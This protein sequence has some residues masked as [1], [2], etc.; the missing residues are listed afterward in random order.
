MA[1]SLRVPYIE[2]SA[3]TN[4]NV[5]EVFMSLASAITKKQMANAPAPYAFVALRCSARLLVAQV[6]IGSRQT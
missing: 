1:D 2:A 6:W 3:K 4:Q 5:A